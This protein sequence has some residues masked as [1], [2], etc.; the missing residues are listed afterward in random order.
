MA[1]VKRGNLNATWGANGATTGIT[2]K[3]QS[4]SAKVGGEKI[5]LKDDIAET[6]AVLYFDETIEMDAE[7]IAAAAATP[8]APGDVIEIAGVQGAIVD[9]AEVKWQNNNAM[10]ISIRATKF[11]NF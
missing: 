1:E 10:M 7:V 6:F 11:A 2:G 9:E 8:P 3:V 4:A 5:E